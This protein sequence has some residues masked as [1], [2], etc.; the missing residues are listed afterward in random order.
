MHRT[1]LGFAL[2]SVLAACNGGAEPQGDTPSASDAATG[3]GR[4]VGDAAEQP[5]AGSPEVGDEGP[6]DAAPAPVD[7]EGPEITAELEVGD[8]AEPPCA[9]LVRAECPTL[10]WALEEDRCETDDGVIRVRVRL[11]EPGAEEL[12]GQAFETK[13]VKVALEAVPAGRV[14][15]CVSRWTRGVEYLVEPEARLAAV[16]Q[17]D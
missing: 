3:E 10:G 1:L 5:A 13:S 14:E 9:V 4:P 12:V 11:T 8:G 6:G 16:L 15:V 7:Y 17:N 2:I